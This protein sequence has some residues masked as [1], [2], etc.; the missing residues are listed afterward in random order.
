MDSIYVEEDYEGDG[1]NY[2]HDIAIVK[3]STKVTISNLVLPACIDWNKFYNVTSGDMGKVS[4]ILCIINHCNIIKYFTRGT[5]KKKL[6][7]F[8]TKLSHL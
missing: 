5:F 4:C 2:H 8:Y 3:L 7:L 6:I 1:L